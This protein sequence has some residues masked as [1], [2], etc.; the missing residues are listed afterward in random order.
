MCWFGGNVI[1][2]L[3]GGRKKK[4]RNETKV[5]GGPFRQLA[6]LYWSLLNLHHS[7]LTRHTIAGQHETTTGHHSL[8]A[9]QTL[10]TQ[11]EKPNQVF[12]SCRFQ[13]W[14]HEFRPLVLRSHTVTAY[15]KS[16]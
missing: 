13:T 11:K 4:G 8:P 9:T 14:H 5:V 10:Q 16:K 1:N 12:I 2:L 6:D 15:P 3:G 7:F